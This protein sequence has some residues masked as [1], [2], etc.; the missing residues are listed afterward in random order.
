MNETYCG[1][2]VPERPLEF[3]PDIRIGFVLTPGFTVLPLAGFIDAVRHSADEA[4]KSRQVFCHWEVLG[5]DLNAV[6]SSAGLSVIPWKTFEEAGRYDYVVIVGGLISQL[7]DIP[8]STLEFIRTQYEAGV[9]LV[10]LCTG[11]F[12]IARA[13]LLSGKRAAIHAH[14]RGEFLE[15]FPETTPID[16]ELYVSDSGIITCPGGTAAIDLAVEILIEH[17]GRSR[18]TKGLTA[19]V[20]DEHR[21]AHEIGRLPFDDLDNCGNWR[22]EQ[23]IG[24]MRQRLSNPDTTQTLAQMLGSTVRQLNRAFQEQ[25]GASPQAVWREMRLQHARWRLMNSKRSV[26]HTAHECGFSDSSHFS[27]WFKLRFGE[28]PRQ[29]RQLRQAGPR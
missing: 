29:Y 15:L 11:S 19:L 8:P 12:A 4:D 2:F 20:V 1:M 10:G 16:T 22:V 7:G 6:T 18:G 17:C 14:H 23:A 9:K 21:A 26:T 25:A 3:D 13:G 5:A 27:R 28:T 24:I